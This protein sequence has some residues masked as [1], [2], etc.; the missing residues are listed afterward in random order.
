MAYQFTQTGAQIQSILDQ[1]GTNTGDIAQNTQDIASLN[2][3]FTADTN[4]AAVSI[5]SGTWTK[6]YEVT[7]AKGLWLIDYAVTFPS[8]S[9]G[10]RG[11]AFATSSSSWSPTRDCIR[12]PAVSGAYTQ[13]SGARIIELNASAGMAIWAYQDSG[14]TQS[15]GPYIR[16]VQLR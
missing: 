14:S 16:Y 15:V 12:I 4:P 11:I 8:N 3:G 13:P 7:L 1:V 6:V 10:Y 2:S 5:A 9:T